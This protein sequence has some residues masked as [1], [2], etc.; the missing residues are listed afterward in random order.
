MSYV[1]IEVEEKKRKQLIDFYNDYM[2]KEK[3]KPEAFNSLDEFKKSAAYQDLPEEEKEQLKQY[4]GK[5]VMVLTFDDADQAIKFIEQAQSKGLFS[6]E[7]ADAAISQ[8]N[9]QN[10]S[11]HRPK[12]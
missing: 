8:I 5:I 12:M 7:Q 10:Q 11:S 1:T 4:E 9:D 6:K 3:S 2:S